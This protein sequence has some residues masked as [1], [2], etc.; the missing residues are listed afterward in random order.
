MVRVNMVSHS[1]ASVCCVSMIFR[2]Y[3]GYEAGC[4]RVSI[5]W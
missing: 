1:V 2:V 4:K 5:E 3:F